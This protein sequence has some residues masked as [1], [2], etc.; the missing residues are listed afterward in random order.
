MESGNQIPRIQLTGFKKEEKKFLVQLLL[1]LN[2]AFFDTEQYRS[3]THLI[4]KQ[5]C[6]SEKFLAACAADYESN[7]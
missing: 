2:C 6:K 7:M 4:A 5:P 1:K 3:C